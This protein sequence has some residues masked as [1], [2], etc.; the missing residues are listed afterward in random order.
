MNI[1]NIGFWVVKISEHR[2]L[3][4]RTVREVKKKCLCLGRRNEHN[5]IMPPKKAKYVLAKT[6]DEMLYLTKLL[7]T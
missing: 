7:E 2:I 1:K 5:S 4:F 3:M 6:V